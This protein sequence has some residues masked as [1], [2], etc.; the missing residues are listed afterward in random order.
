MPKNA[1]SFMNDSGNRRDVWTL[2]V[3]FGFLL[4]LLTSLLSDVRHSHFI[5]LAGNPL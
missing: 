2:G 1:L 4:F 5:A 3:L